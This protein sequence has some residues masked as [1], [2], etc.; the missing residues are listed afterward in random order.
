MQLA[1]LC[2]GGF[3]LFLRYV[4]RQLPVSSTHWF[5]DVGL[6]ACVAW[7]VSPADVLSVFTRSR[8]KVCS[9]QSLVWRWRLQVLLFLGL[10]SAIF[11]ATL[12]I[13]LSF[14]FLDKN[15]I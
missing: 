5:G 8:C 6:Q 12:C 2:Q 7:G 1:V 3:D 14:V 9:L 11:F 10:S 4:L 15:Q 13:K